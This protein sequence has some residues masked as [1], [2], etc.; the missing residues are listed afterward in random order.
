MNKILSFLLL[1]GFLATAAPLPPADILSKNEVLAEY[2]GLKD[3]PC[4]F[5]TSLC[6]DQ[7]G[8]ATTLALFKVLEQVHYEKKGEYGDAPYAL[9][10]TV[11]VDVGCDIEGQDEGITQQI[12][13]LK[14]GEKVRLE[15][16]HYYVNKKGNRYPVRPVTALIPEK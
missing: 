2:V 9:G 5:R 7:C 14:G 3:L 16:T 10:E 8:H 15:V 11:M 13:K 6:P 4:R 1:S 12:K